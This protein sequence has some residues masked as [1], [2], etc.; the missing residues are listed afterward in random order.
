[1][2][3]PGD[4]IQMRDRPECDAVVLESIPENHLLKVRIH[5]DFG[6]F[7]YYTD[8]GHWEAAEPRTTNQEP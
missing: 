8:A 3:A 7:E 4:P 6:P 5:T 1:M 2:F